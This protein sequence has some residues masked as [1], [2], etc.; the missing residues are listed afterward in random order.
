MD[1]DQRQSAL[2]RAFAR[3]GVTRCAIM[4]TTFRSGSTWIGRIMDRHGLAG[5]KH[6]RLRRID[7]QEN[8]DDFLDG[9]LAAPSGPVFAARL[10]WVQRNRLADH[11]HFARSQSA[12]FAAQFPDAA[13][14]LLRRRD[15]YA[16]GI[17]YWRAKVTNRWHAPAAWGEGEP[18]IPY[19]YD[20]IDACVRELAMHD[21]RWG[22][23]FAQARIAP[24]TVWYEDFVADRSL[25]DGYMARFGLTLRETRSDM[26]ILGDDLTRR[27]RDRYLDD[28][29]R[30]SKG[31]DATVKAAA[32]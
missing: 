16:Q 3:H 18:Q 22:D 13:W 12:A 28:L 26:K 10:M 2:A 6:E 7:T 5:M 23:F 25:L 19:D 29:F 21:Q 27:Y 24:Q 8:P 17:S 20:A 30:R 11:L 32:G 9:V 31:L 1:T 4:A 14:L 15:V